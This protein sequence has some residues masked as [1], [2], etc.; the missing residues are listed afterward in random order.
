MDKI[1][2]ISNNKIVDSSD[3]FQTIINKKQSFT[4]V[5]NNVKLDVK[6]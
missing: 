3:L 1:T 6:L 4:I 2:I 5:W